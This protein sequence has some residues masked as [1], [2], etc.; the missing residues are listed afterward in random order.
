MTA[1]LAMPLAW[2]EAESDTER[3]QTARVTIKADAYVNGPKVELG[4]IAEFEG[5]NTELLRG[6]EISNAPL[7]GNS[8]RM[9]AALIAA[10]IRDS[11]FDEA[12]VAVDGAKVVRAVTRSQ[13]VTSDEL[14]ADLHEFVMAELPWEPENTFV[15]VSSPD[16]KIVLPE[17]D[18][19]L[20][21]KPNPTYRYVGAGS[22]RGQI[23]VDDVVKRNIMCRVKIEAYGDVVVAV[24]D[25]PRGSILSASNLDVEQRSLEKL[26]RGTFDSMESLVGFEAKSTIFPGAVI[27]KR[28][29]RALRLVKRNQIVP[30]LVQKGALQVRTRAKALADASPGDIVVCVGVD[31][32]ERFQGVL[33]GDGVVVLR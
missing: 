27:T 1:L 16:L 18:V 11:G 3:I 6:V 26:P 22:F 31:S 17:G 25:I 24:D 7:P 5:V 4:E 12:A 15:E 20:R 9:D 19:R 29:V 28:Q 30:V 21:W 14:V 10:K 8:K 23:L 2:G 32:K 33:R 13:T